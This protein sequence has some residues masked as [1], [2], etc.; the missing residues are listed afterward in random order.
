L[1]VVA[2]LVREVQRAASCSMQ[3]K[4]FAGS[5]DTIAATGK[6]SANHAT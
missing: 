1:V 3:R 4:L 5:V 6:A 2:V